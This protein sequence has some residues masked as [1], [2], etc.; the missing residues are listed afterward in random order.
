MKLVYSI[1]GLNYSGGTE[2]VTAIEANAMAE[3]GHEV[4]IV[5]FVG[6]GEQPF[7]AISPK[8]K[9]HYLAPPKDRHLFPF[10]DIR[11]IVLLKKLYKQINPDF[12]II[13]DAGRSF[14]NIPASKGYKTIT[15]EHFNIKTCYRPTHMLSRRIAAKYSDCIV[16]LTSADAQ[17]YIDMLHAKKA[18]SIYN[19]ITIDNS[20]KTGLRNKRVLAIGRIVTQK[21]FDLLTEAWAV[22][23]KQAPDWKLRIIGEGNKRDL[24][25]SKLHEFG[26]KESVEILPP[27]KN[28]VAEYTNASI[29]AMSSRFEGLPLVLIEAMSVGLPIVSFDCETGPRDIV[30]DRVTGVLVPT[31]DVERLGCE[32][33][34]LMNDPLLLKKYSE[35]SIIESGKFEIG[36]IIDEWEKLLATL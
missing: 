5:S 14:V 30:N 10:R 8:V 26:V 18:L 23:V 28:V 11:R 13:V 36:H 12:I 35:N 22:A 17:N 33:A 2:R 31:L 29:Y 4:H 1:K 27:T 32:L 7:F 6:K 34:K 9:C 24:L 20:V 25:E 19:P 3:R 15:W 16:T 21:G